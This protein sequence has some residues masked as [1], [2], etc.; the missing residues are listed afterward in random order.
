[1][2]MATVQAELSKPS[3]VFIA[4]ARCKTRKRRCDGYTPRCSN[5]AAHDAECKYATVRKTR[6]P[7]RRQKDTEEQEEQPNMPHSH[8][9]TS[10]DGNISSQIRSRTIDMIDLRLTHPIAHLSQSQA[11]LN[12]RDHLP[13]VPDFLLPG[14]FDRHLRAIQKDVKEAI[15]KRGFT[16]LMPSHIARR[17][18]E[19]SFTN[20]MSEHPLMSISNFMRLLDAQYAASTND[21]ADDP[22]RW[23]TVN[24]VVALAIRSKTA[25]G[26]E[27]D[28]SPITQNFYLNATMVVHQLILLPPS[29]LFVQA[30]LAM[31]LFARGIPDTQAFV[32]LVTNATRQLELFHRRQPAESSKLCPHKNHEAEQV[33][34]VAKKLNEEISLVI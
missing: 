22:A 19:N 18:I 24:A 30:L 13:I 2:S 21:P 23:A 33:R 5:C 1:M 10:D 28:I 9:L 26:S 31:A 14:S 25:A 34:Q 3:R 6:G 27:H 4:C 20:I 29:M 32:M 7:G 11:R 12:T 8:S 17:L 16:S 15:D